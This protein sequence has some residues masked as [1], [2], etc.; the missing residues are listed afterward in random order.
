MKVKNISASLITLRSK[1]GQDKILP[2]ETVEIKKE[3]EEFAKV[4]I[5]DGILKE[6]KSTTKA[7]DL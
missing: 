5:S 7:S 1:K 2:L 6:V 4:L 3:N